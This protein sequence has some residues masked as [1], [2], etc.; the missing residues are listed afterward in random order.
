MSAGI[1]G[2]CTETKVGIDNAK[3]MSVGLSQVQV[4]IAYIHMLTSK[5][6]CA[7][8]TQQEFLDF[9]RFRAEGLLILLMTIL[10][11]G[12]SL[13]IK[14]ARSGSAVPIDLRF[15]SDNPHCA[16]PCR[17]EPGLPHDHS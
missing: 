8:G 9:R 7:V 15:N 12:L 4:L 13:F 16:M 14:R 1:P 3:W 5:R 17:L 2:G 6:V 11:T 10:L